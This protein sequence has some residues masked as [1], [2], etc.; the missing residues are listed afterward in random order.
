MA[1]RQKMGA[2]ETKER[3]IAAVARL[4]DRRS[5][6]DLSVKEIAAAAGVNHGLVHRYFGSK[7]NLVRESIA[8]T[9]ARISADIPRAGTAGWTFDLLRTHPELARILA[10]C[11][12]DGPHDLLA[13]AKPPPDRVELHS[14]QIGEALARFGLPGITDPHV[15]NALGLAAMLG[16]IVFRPLFDAGYRLPPDADARIEAIIDLIDSV[17][18]APPPTEPPRA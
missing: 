16:W 18:F 8:R 9:N 5:V 15:L 13:A 10:R 14:F 6:A 3:L 7:E 12:I 1:R 11:C 17:V 4:L 2:E